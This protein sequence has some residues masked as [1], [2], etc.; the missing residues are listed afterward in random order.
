MPDEYR[1]P[2]PK[3]RPDV[4]VVLSYKT[5]KGI[6]FDERNW[7][8]V[9]FSRGLKSAKI[10]LGICGGL[11][12]A[13]TCMVELSK[14]FEEANLDW[15]IETIIKHAHDWITKKRGPNE[16]SYR[17]GLFKALTERSREP[18]NPELLKTGESLFDSLRMLKSPEQRDKEDSIE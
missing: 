3:V 10:L 11:R 16:N 13:D 15:T 14:K 18:D 7:D 9:H 1:L 4:Y 2:D 5:L 6:P 17:A 8:K 12:Q